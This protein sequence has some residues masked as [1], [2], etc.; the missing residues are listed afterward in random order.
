V[1]PEDKNQKSCEYI[2]NVGESASSEVFWPEDESHLDFTAALL[3]AQ[4]IARENLVD[5][6]V[7]RVIEYSNGKTKRKVLA[8]CNF[9]D[10]G[11][12]NKASTIEAD[13]SDSD[14]DGSDEQ[15]AG[16]DEELDRLRQENATLN[17][18]SHLRQELAKWHTWKT[19]HWDDAAG[20]TK[21][22]LAAKAA[23]GRMA[24]RVTQFEA[25]TD[26]LPE[27]EKP[28]GS[29]RLKLLGFALVIGIAY[30]AYHFLFGRGWLATSACFLVWFLLA[31]LYLSGE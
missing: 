20:M 2:V 28:K 10:M 21:G 3:R 15:I 30:T 6:E 24:E 14:R 5:T 9:Y 1:Q 11:D 27:A 29:N 7:E 13:G 23:A 18:L 31:S 12:P 4:T 8:R 26:K 17:E 19:D 22:E 16:I 25:V